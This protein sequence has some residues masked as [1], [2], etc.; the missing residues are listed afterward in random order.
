MYSSLGYLSPSEL[1]NMPSSRLVLL[2][3]LITAIPAGV[4]GQVGGDTIYWSPDRALHWADFQATPMPLSPYAAITTAGIFYSLTYSPKSY[5][6][7][8]YCYFLKSRSWS[9]SKDRAQLL[10][11]EQGHF[12]ITELYARK[13]QLAFAAYHYHFATV[14]ADLK[15]IFAGINAEKARMNEQYDRET[16]L[17]ANAAQQTRWNKKIAQALKQER[18]TTAP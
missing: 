16:D 1:C 8:V 7:R 13:L 18:S 14:S 4:Y 12:D 9:R 3:G 17:S 6:T 15:N 11:H 2:I 10:K 5:R